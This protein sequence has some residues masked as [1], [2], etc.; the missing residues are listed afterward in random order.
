MNYDT[1]LPLD[2]INF[3][4]KDYSTEHIH[5]SYI[6]GKKGT[7]QILLNLKGETLLTVNSIMPRL[8][9]DIVLVRKEAFWGL[10][11]TTGEFLLPATCSEIEW[12]DDV[13]ALKYENKWKL[14]HPKQK[15][16]LLEQSYDSVEELINRTRYNQKESFLLVEEK[17]KWGVLDRNL[18]TIIPIQKEQLKPLLI[19]DKYSKK[20]TQ[21]LVEEK[22]KWS[23]LDINNNVVLELEY[24]NIVPIQWKSNTLNLS[25]QPLFVVT[26]NEKKGITDATGTLILPIVYDAIH[27]NTETFDGIFEIKQAKNRM[28]I[29]WNGNKMEMLNIKP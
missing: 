15:G 12:Y 18:K 27:F 13:L 2:I 10:A 16:I 7:D 4:P 20:K 24:D 29:Q 26:K 8:M 21:F 11:K 28:R 5:T 22:G 6:I 19:I 3:N 9:G 23:V 1:L 25:Q 14:F 17:G